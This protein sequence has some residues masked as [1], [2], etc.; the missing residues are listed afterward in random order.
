M[1][2]LLL[3]VH[4]LGLVLADT[5][6]H[7]M[8]DRS[9]SCSRLCADAG[10]SSVC[11]SN[12]RRCRLLTCGERWLVDNDKDDAGLQVLVDLHGGDP[13]D[14]I[15]NAEYQEIKERVMAEVS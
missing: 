14:E 5:F 4:R 7:T 12:S 2:R 6:V 9:P 10:E 3:L 8:C 1:D 13:N 11:P 15:A